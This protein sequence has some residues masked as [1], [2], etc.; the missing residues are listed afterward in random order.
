MHWEIKFYHSYFA[1]NV[2]ANAWTNMRYDQEPILMFYE[3]HHPQIKS[4]YLADVLRLRVVIFDN[5]LCF[6]PLPLKKERLNYINGPSTY[7]LFSIW[8][9]NSKIF[10]FGPSNMLCQSV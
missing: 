10:L 9:L 1:G 3:E 5:F 6:D 7:L 2:C 8:S 4:L